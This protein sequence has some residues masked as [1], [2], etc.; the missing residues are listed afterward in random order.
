MD[1][2]A[3]ETN[4]AQ[5]TRRRWLR[6]SLGLIVVT[7]ALGGICLPFWVY[8]AKRQRA[9]ALAIELAG[10][11][12]VYDYEENPPLDSPAAQPGPDWLCN[13]LGVDY[14][15]DIT[16]VTLPPDATNST[17]AHLSALTGLERLYLTSTQIDDAG[18]IHLSGLTSLRELRLDGTDVSDAGLVHLCHLRRLQT[19][20]LD[21]TRVSGDGKMRL[22]QALPRCTIFR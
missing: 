5:P 3:L 22:E 17:A 16:W 19:L 20:W 18:L 11:S 14:F 8:G 15:A 7:V 13:R 4:E 2:T 9:A 10:G 1:D 21:G 6:V 12:Y